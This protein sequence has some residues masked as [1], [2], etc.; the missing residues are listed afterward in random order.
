MTRRPT[1][2]IL[3]PVHNRAT[4]IGDCIRSAL[5]QTVRDLEVVV[6]D[7]ASTDG[8]WAVC[9]QF[10]A[11]DPRVRIFRNDANIGAV[12][13]WARCIAEARGRFGKLLFSD[14]LIAPDYLERTL[15]YLED[16]AVGLVFHEVAIGPVPGKGRIGYRLGRPSGT[17]SSDAFIALATRTN[18][19]S[20][21]PGSAFFRMADLRAHLLD[22]IPAATTREVAGHGAGPDLLLF[23]LAARKYPKVAYVRAP[24]AFFRSHTGSL[25]IDLGRRELLPCYTQAKA[26]F[27]AQHRSDNPPVRRRQLRQALAYEW[28]RWNLTTR[29]YIPLKPFLR[30]FLES[31]ERV[32]AFTLARVLAEILV[33]QAGARLGAAKVP[34]WP[35]GSPEG[36]VEAAHPL[37]ETPRSGPG[38]LRVAFLQHVTPGYKLPLF[39]RLAVLDDVDL[40]LFVGDKG[41]PG[42]PPPE[43]VSG[44]RSVALRNTVVSLLGLAVSWQATRGVLRVRDFD[45]MILPEGLAT[46]SNYWLVLKCKACGVAVGAYSHGFNHQRKARAVSRG[47]ESIR[48]A[49]H[50]RLD[51]IIVYGDAIAD[52]LVR[53]SGLDRGRVF[54]ARNTLDLEAIRARADAITVADSADLRKRMGVAPGDV[55]LVYVGRITPLKNPQWVVDAVHRLRAE[56]VPVRAL[57]VG[58]GELE[59]P[60]RDRVG[61]D[62]SLADAVHFVG[63]V[64][65]EA[66]DAY[67]KAADIAVMPAMTGLAVVH[68]FAHGKPYVTVHSGNHGPEIGY[69]IDGQNGFIAENSLA[70]F[71]DCIRALATDPERRAEIGRNALRFARTELTVD[72][73][74]QGFLEAFEWVRHGRTPPRSQPPPGPLPAASRAE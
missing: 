18:R 43:P 53:E 69:L 71:T 5:A 74:I 19:V 59:R 13:N 42:Q 28:F 73:Q 65:V 22:A 60:L 3:I 4:L 2:S 62:P 29:D 17:L 27:L 64:P 39:Q 32:G 45:M 40:T 1:T 16:P 35:A 55:L 21:S 25:T 34:P 24:L 12:R 70:A 15:P 31:P 48:A 58:G 51:F 23:L 7:N 14:D 63:R 10:A 54:V 47:I 8:T 52:R 38:P 41:L 57:F 49:L 44:V 11:A 66:V 6:V 46:L 72:K 20:A 33:E 67:L 61:S 68:A 37:D 9:R 26:W 36:A 50:R 56:G 30:R